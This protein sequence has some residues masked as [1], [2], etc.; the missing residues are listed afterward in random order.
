MATAEKRREHELDLL[1]L[2]E[3]DGLDVREQAVCEL[4][5]ASLAAHVRTVRLTL[6]T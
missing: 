1:R 5:G 6:E 3:H 2:P 4:D